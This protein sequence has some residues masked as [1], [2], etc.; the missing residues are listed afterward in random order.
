MTRTNRFAF[1][2]MTALTTVCVLATGCVP[3]GVGQLIPDVITIDTAGLFDLT[4][5]M[6]DGGSSY[7]GGWY[8]GGSSYTGGMYDGGAGY[9]GGNDVYYDDAS[10][11]GAY[12]DAVYGSDNDPYY[13]EGSYADEYYYPNDYAYS[14]DYSYD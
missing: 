6:Y 12:Y 4:G 2:G 3:D 13:W 8:D 10:Y 11:I 1:L 5:G 9:G 7:G 14:Y